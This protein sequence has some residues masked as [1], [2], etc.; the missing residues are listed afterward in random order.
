MSAHKAVVRDRI[1]QMMQ[2]YK[3]T[4][5]LTTG[6]ELCAFD[7]L[8]DRPQSA[9]QVA[10]AIGVDPRGARILLDALAAIGLVETDGDTYHLAPASEMY[11]V[12]DR[13]EYVGDMARVFA[14]KWEWEAV[15]RLPEAVRRGGTVLDVHA[16]TPEYAYWEDFA[17]SVAAVAKPAAAAL[18]GVLHEWASGHS[19][20]DVLDVAAGHGLY[21]FTLACGHPRSR[22]W[23]LDWPNVLHIT[24]LHAAKLGLS[25]RARFIGGDMFEVELGGP[26]DLI[27]AGNVLHHFSEERCVTLLRR[28]AC[29]T[30]PGGRIAVVGFALENLPPRQDPAPYLFAVLMLVWTHGGEVH[31]LKVYHRMLVESGFA[32]P[33]VHRIAGLP[34]RIVVAER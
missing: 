31:R 14:S 9:S 11:L 13:P 26:Y 24:R 5:L 23:A 1:L 27:I 10:A 30:K 33:T 12:R 20:L 18:A 19:R 28:L 6:L 32:R 3:V 2:A 17:T 21:G 16:E 25:D 22:V 4:S 7:Q 34:F 29:A 8:A 15:R